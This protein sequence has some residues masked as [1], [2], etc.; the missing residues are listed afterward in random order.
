MGSM[1]AVL[2][3]ASCP[4]L[5]LPCLHSPLWPCQGWLQKSVSLFDILY[6]SGSDNAGKQNHFIIV[7]VSVLLSLDVRMFWRS[8]SC[9][10]CKG[11]SSGFV[12]HVFRD[13]HMD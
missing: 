13:P 1:G 9:P 7:L 6:F 5:Q 3:C 12:Q 10:L 11:V 8:G 4:G 2:S